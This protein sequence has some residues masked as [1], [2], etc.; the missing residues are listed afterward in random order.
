MC[1]EQCKD[2]KRGI[3]GEVLWEEEEEEEEEEEV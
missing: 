2:A 1:D 3:S